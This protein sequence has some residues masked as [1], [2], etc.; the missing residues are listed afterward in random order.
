MS[1]ILFDEADFSEFLG[2]E[3]AAH[4]LGHAL[5]FGEVWLEMGLLVDPVNPVNGG[6][7]AEVR[8]VP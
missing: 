3:I 2:P 5:G 7:G 8:N 1:S 4:E 6:P